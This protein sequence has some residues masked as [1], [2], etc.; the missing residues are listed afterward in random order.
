MKWGH[1]QI[2][3]LPSDRCSGFKTVPL[4]SKKKKKIYVHSEPQNVTVYGNGSLQMKL[5]KIDHIVLGWV[6]NP[7]TFVFIRGERH[8]HPEKKAMWK[9]R[10]RRN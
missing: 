2:L 1:V 9:Q 4:P 10:Q 5:V 8:R 6:L 7:M 3:T